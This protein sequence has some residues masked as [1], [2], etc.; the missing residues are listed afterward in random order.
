MA[1]PSAPSAGDQWTEFGRTWVYDGSG[2]G[3]V[4]AAATSVLP[5]RTLA[6]LVSPAAEKNRQFRVIDAPGGEAVV[7][8]DG[9][10]YLRVSD[11]SP[12][13]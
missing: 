5:E 9:T 12:V 13:K 8:C 1:W 7:Y 10:S 4:P 6:Q 3:S 11:Q 2:W